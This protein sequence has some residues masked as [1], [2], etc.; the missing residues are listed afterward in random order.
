[1][2]II[3]MDTKYLGDNARSYFEEHFNKKLLMDIM[4][5][6]FIQEILNT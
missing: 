4:D 2:K 6:Y 1:M 5:Q 3:K